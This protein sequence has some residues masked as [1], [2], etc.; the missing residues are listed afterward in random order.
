MTFSDMEND[1]D[2]KP[3]V[4]NNVFYGKII[5]FDKEN[6]ITEQLTLLLHEAYEKSRFQ[7]HSTI[8]FCSSAIL[9]KIKKENGISIELTSFTKIFDSWS[10]AP[11]LFS[12]VKEENINNNFI[13]VSDHIS[14]FNY[15]NGIKNETKDVVLAAVKGVRN[16]N[17]HLGDFSSLNDF[18]NS[19]YEH[20]KKSGSFSNSI[21]FFYY[22]DDI[23]LTRLFLSGSV[24]VSDN[25]M[26]VGVKPLMKSKSK[27]SMNLFEVHMS[28]NTIYSCNIVN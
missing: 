16:T 28:D 3:I 17:F 22:S 19:I 1:I 23:L 20:S 25:M 9:E 18:L 8:V 12:S 7:K 26:K 6:G 2:F 13:V 15:K 14:Y 27:N 10:P 4:D 11:I 5:D 21:K 24:N